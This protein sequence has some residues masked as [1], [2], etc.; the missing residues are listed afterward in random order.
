MEAAVIMMER[1]NQRPGLYHMPCKEREKASKIKKK[2]LI[3]QYFFHCK[4][5]ARAWYACPCLSP[6][7]IISVRYYSSLLSCR[8]P[9]EG[10]TH[11]VRLLLLLHHP[12]EARYPS[13]MPL[14]KL[15]QC[16]AHKI[17]CLRAKEVM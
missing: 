5:L 2:A 6:A 17:R 16:S 11:I 9:S 13:I 4:G 14:A 1:K 3:P 8:V 12:T 7:K 10:L 15:L